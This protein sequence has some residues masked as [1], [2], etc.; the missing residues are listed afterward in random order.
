MK[1]KAFDPDSLM[2]RVGRDYL[3]VDHLPRGG[4][5]IQIGIDRGGQALEWNNVRIPRRHVKRLLE[6]IERGPEGTK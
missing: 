5:L 6:Y 4:A 2:F 3:T 1:R